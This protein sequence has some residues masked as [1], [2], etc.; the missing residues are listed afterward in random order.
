[1]MFLACQLK[2]E[3]KQGDFIHAFCQ[4]TLPSH[5]QHICEPPLGCQV[6]PPNTYLWL[7]KTLYWL[8]RSPKHWYEKSK[9][10]LATIGIHPS[11]N[12]LCLYSGIII[13][14]SAPLYLEMYVDEFIYFSTDPAVEKKFEVTLSLLLNVESTGPPQYFLGLK[15][16][17]KKEDNHLRIFYLPRGSSNI[18]SSSCRFIRYFGKNKQNSIPNRISSRQ[19]SCSIKSSTFCSRKDRRWLTILR[20]IA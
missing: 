14:G 16:K 12:A 19:N 4:S 5:E 2:T 20:R 6:T 10:V 9:K 18:T 13:P 7:I 11:P 1:M 15:V 8:K 17:C 3:P